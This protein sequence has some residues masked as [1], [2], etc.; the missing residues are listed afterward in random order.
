M[1][2]IPCLIKSIIFPTK[3]DM[4]YYFVC[5]YPLSLFYYFLRLYRN[6]IAFLYTFVN[7]S[8]IFHV[9]SY[10]F[11]N[12]NCQ[13]CCLSGLLVSFFIL[14]KSYKYNFPSLSHLT[15]IAIS[16]IANPLTYAIIFLPFNHTNIEHTISIHIQ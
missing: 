5:S 8:L 4:T 12:T 10:I 16:I 1:P 2:S 6:I 7:S 11:H 15:S 14:K 9:F 13:I 3:Y